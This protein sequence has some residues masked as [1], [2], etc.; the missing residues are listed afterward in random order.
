MP[1]DWG[2]SSP[3]ARQEA[4][5]PPPTNR[6][7]S[8]VSKRSLI[9]ATAELLYKHPTLLLFMLWINKYRLL[10]GRTFGNVDIDD[11]DF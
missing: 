7:M 5:Q 1:L 6:P 4:Q 2:H 9:S 3:H 10:I 11:P 8:I